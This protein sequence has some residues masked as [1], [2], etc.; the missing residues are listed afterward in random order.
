MWKKKKGVW[1]MSFIRGIAYSQDE[2]MGQEAT[3]GMGLSSAASDASSCCHW[4]H[5]AGFAGV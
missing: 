5:R 1:K 3:V 4:A 2:G